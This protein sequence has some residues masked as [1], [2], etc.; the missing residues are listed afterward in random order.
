MN[1]RPPRRDD[2]TRVLEVC[3]PSER[4]EL[5]PNPGQELARAA[6]RGAVVGFALG[7][8]LAWLLLR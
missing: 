4:L 1:N 3:P 7:F 6:W 5:P 2:R 8:A